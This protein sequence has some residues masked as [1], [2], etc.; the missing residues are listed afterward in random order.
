M[1]GGG[2]KKCLHDLRLIKPDVRVLMTSGYANG[3]QTED[4]TLAGAAG[5]IH[6][7]Y[8]PED[9]LNSIRKI[10]DGPNYSG[11][12]PLQSNKGV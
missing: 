3:R 6:K 5:F 1:P 11:T 7:P 12:D 8:R 4:L 2:G 10:I 9:L